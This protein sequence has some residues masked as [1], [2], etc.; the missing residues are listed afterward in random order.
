[1]SNRENETL[2]FLQVAQ[3]SNSSNVQEVT[4]DPTLRQQGGYN[5]RTLDFGRKEDPGKT[6]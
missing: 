5:K 4:M 2:R 3:C 6:A 1:M